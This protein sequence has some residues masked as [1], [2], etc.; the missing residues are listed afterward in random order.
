[1]TLG[2]RGTGIGL[3]TTREIVRRHGGDIWVEPCYFAEGR[4]I[5]EKDVVEENM[6]AEELSKGNSFVFTIPGK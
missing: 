1:V 4:C 6:I 5:A 3:H 2:R